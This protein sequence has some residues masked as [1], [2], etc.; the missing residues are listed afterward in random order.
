MVWRVFFFFYKS[1]NQR[2][3]GKERWLRPHRSRSPWAGMVKRPHFNSTARLSMQI[4]SSPSCINRSWN[5][6]IGMN[7]DWNDR[8]VAIKL[9]VCHVLVLLR[10]DSIIHHSLWNLWAC[11]DDEVHHYL[12][13]F[14]G[15]SFKF[16]PSLTVGLT[17]LDKTFISQAAKA[18]FPNNPCHL[19]Y[20]IGTAL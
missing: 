19:Q 11:D 12:K 2:F 5:Q 1:T 14:Q 15:G 9:L 7:P 8:S 10:C 18:P 16:R 17:C 6:R 20:E 4:Y 13:E 3:W